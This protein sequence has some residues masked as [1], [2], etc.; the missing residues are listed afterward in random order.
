M[1]SIILSFL[2]LLSHHIGLTQT[3]LLDS[4]KGELKVAK[5]DTTK[6]RIYLLLGDACEKKDKLE[7]TEPALNLVDKL[8]LKEQNSYE[9]TKLIEQEQALL[10]SFGFYYRYSNEAVWDKAMTYLQS[11]LQAIE[12]TGDRKR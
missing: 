5:A 1:R 8:L 11:R 10:N 2:F 6:L 4:L 12:K 9:R 3:R 7:F